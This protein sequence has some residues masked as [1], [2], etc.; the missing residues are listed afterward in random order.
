M[1]YNPVPVLGGPTV[2]VPDS[3]W[4]PNAGVANQTPG[5]MGPPQLVQ[6]VTQVAAVPIPGT[7][8]FTL[9]AVSTVR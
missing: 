8:G 9:V 4:N 7:L 3:F 1:P 2:P 6:P 5:V